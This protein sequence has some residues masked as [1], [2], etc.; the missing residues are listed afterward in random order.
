MKMTTLQLK[1][2]K[3][4]KKTVLAKNSCQNDQNGQISHNRTSI[5]RPSNKMTHEIDE[6]IE[7]LKNDQE[8]QKRVEAYKWR[9][10]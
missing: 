6:F 2:V 9:N 4:T 1:I 3:T 7:R 8:F 10:Q 5:I